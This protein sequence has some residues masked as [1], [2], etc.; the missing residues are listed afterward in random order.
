MGQLPSKPQKGAKFQVIGA[1][2][3]RT[4]TK[5]LNEALSILLKGPCHDSGIQSLG[6]SPHEIKTWLDIMELA[7]LQSGPE[8]EQKMDWL[9]QSIFDGYVATM[10]C[11]AASLVPEIMRA[12]PEAIVI[13]TTREQKSW[14]KSMKNMNGMMSTWYLPVIV[15]WL[16]KAQGY[17]VWGVRFQ[18]LSKWRYGS[19]GIREPTKEIHEDH[20]RKV[21]PKEKV[22]WYNVADGWEP[23]CKI[24]NVPVPD[25]PFPHNN[26]KSEAK[27]VWERHVIAGAS[28]WLFVLGI[29]AVTF[30]YVSGWLEEQTEAIEA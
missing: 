5:T 16:R 21:V 26:S 7:P 3:C 18:A 30:W 20:I 11:P 8:D 15:M 14:W 19:E 17:G 27:K 24:L 12:Y 29:L 22:H 2:M 9:I 6:G 25:Q 10:D 28:S 4:G 23:L 13:V 1:G